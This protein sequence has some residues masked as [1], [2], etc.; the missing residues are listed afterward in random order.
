MIDGPLTVETQTKILVRLPTVGNPLSGVTYCQTLRRANYLTRTGGPLPM[1]S[2]LRLQRADVFR[3]Y[4]L[5]PLRALRAL[6]AL[7]LPPP[8][9]LELQRNACGS[10]L[11]SSLFSRYR[12]LNAEN[13][14]NNRKA[15]SSLVASS[16]A[17]NG[18]S[19]LQQAGEMPGDG[20]SPRACRRI[21]RE[22]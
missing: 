10:P 14:P 2:P 18:P 11:H 5:R 1:C 12:H 15:V 9:L 16:G 6:R 22:C 17:G 8:L 13:K 3:P 19:Y 7:P 21:A 20:A 4:C